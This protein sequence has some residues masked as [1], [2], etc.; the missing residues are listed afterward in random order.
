MTPT[1]V[2]PG[3]E[4]DVPDVLVL[5]VMMGQGA[6]G[7]VM[8][9]KIRKDSRFDKMPYT[10]VDI[11]DGADGFSAFLASLSTR[12]SCWWTTT[13]R[14]VSSRRFCS[15]RSNVSSPAKAVVSRGD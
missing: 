8:A 1:K 12:S 11:D 5:D 4:K 14:R 6:S 13:S 10:N 7:F 2:M 3:L 9:R 15:R